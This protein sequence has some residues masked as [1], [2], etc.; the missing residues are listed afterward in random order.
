MVSDVD[1][2]EKL[3]GFLRRLSD[4]GEPVAKIV[5]GRCVQLRG[6]NDEWETLSFRSLGD[7]F[8]AAE[9]V[10]T[11]PP[12]RYIEKPYAEEEAGV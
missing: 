6:P 3:N 9:L 2:L 8:A 10:R 12:R 11:L 1:L 5:G 4:D 7:Y